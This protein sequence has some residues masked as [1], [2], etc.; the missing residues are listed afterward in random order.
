MSFDGIM[1]R[2]PHLNAQLVIATVHQRL[3]EIQINCY[4]LRLQLRLFQPDIFEV[5]EARCR[6]LATV[7]AVHLRYSSRSSRYDIVCLKNDSNHHRIVKRFVIKCYRQ[8][9]CPQIQLCWWRHE[10]NPVGAEI[11]GS[12]G[13]RRDGRGGRCGCRRCCLDELKAAAIASLFAV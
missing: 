6:G 8:A 12:C 1:P 2:D 9:G 11:I 10:Q 7:H 13:G 3:C 5:V 4:L